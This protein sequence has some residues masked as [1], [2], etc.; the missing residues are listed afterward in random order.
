MHVQFHDPNWRWKVNTQSAYLLCPQLVLSC[1]FELVGETESISMFLSRRP[2][3]YFGLGIALFKKVTDTKNLLIRVQRNEELNIC[4]PTFTHMIWLYRSDFPVTL[5]GKIL[6]SITHHKMET[7]RML[8]L[9]NYLFR[10]VSFYR[11]K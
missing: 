9:D 6:V 5:P 11:P 8:K 10:G 2:C 4:L 3:S 1:N 7:F